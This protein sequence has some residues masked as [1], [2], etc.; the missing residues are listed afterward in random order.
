MAQGAAS[1]GLSRVA[2]GGGPRGAL[3]ALS[4]GAAGVCVGV[5]VALA[6]TC[7]SPLLV[8]FATSA[9]GGG[10]RGRGAGS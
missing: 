3:G 6:D 9:W 7:P 5:G 8:L 1:L 10:E 2:L 4:W